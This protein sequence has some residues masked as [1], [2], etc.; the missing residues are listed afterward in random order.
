MCHLIVVNLESFH[1]FTLLFEYFI[2]VISN[3]K[4]ECGV[5]IDMELN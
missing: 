4:I 5:N 3:L 2:G 1:D